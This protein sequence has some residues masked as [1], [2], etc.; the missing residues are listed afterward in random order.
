MSNIFR[1]MHS[2][3]L[4]NDSDN[5]IPIG[6]LENVFTPTPIEIQI[7]SSPPILVGFPNDAPSVP[8]SGQ[9][10]LCLAAECSRMAFTQI[11]LSIVQ[12]TRIKSVSGIMNGLHK[13][14]GATVASNDVIPRN[15]REEM[16]ELV[17]WHAPTPTC[18]LSLDQNSEQRASFDF[19]LQI[20]GYVPAVTNTA[21][22][23]ISYAVTATAVVDGCK[24]LRKTTWIPVQRVIPCSSPTSEKR[25]LR[26]Y[27]DTRLHSKLTVPAVVN[28]TRPF[29]VRLLFQGLTVQGRKTSSRLAI[30]KCSW[31]VDE[32]IRVVSISN[33]GLEYSDTL[34]CKEMKRHV[35]RL[36]GGRCGNRWAQDNGSQIQCDFEITLPH[37][38]QASCDVSQCRGPL[39]AGQKTTSD[40][41]DTSERL[42][43]PTVYL[44]KIAIS[45]S[46][47]L[48]VEFALVEEI[49]DNKTGKRV[50][51]DPWQMPGYGCT[52][53]IFVVHLHEGRALDNNEL[54]PPYSDLS[55]G[56]PP[57]YQRT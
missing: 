31:R 2:Q 56:E 27:P 41:T 35:R 24:T 55:N 11:R 13:G 33:P 53:Q 3:D 48:V 30:R 50:N 7:A 26:R 18:I 15:G 37:K 28:P 19:I 6:Q 36:A 46:H 16:E 23:S 1:R 12:V 5:L 42:R 44:S 20:P 52:N 29:L 51:L 47:I 17:H 34:E 54:L 21:I 40:S 10:K 4:H 45:V 49:Y 9:L 38:A 57:E 39:F 14:Y 43:S 25:F 22:G 8:I 32:I